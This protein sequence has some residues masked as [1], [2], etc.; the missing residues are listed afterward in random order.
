MNKRNSAKPSGNAPE[1]AAPVRDEAALPLWRQ[2]LREP[3]A[4]CLVVPIALRPWL[5]GITYPTDNFYFLWYLALLFAI[6]SVRLLLRGEA[7]RFGKPIALFAAFFVIA[8]LTGLGTVE[9]Y[10]TYRMLLMWAM[11]FFLFILVTNGI[12]TRLA[13]AILLGAFA[14][15]YLAESLWGLLHLHYVL[16]FVRHLVKAQPGLL[17]QYFGTE[18]LT[19]ELAHRL[20]TNRA[21]GS[22]LFP[23]ALGA[24]LVLGIPYALAG[25][26]RGICE[27][28]T[29]WR[30][31]ASSVAAIPVARRVLHAVLVGATA[32]VVTG[33]AA[34]FLF[35]FFAFFAYEGEPWSEHM[36]AFSL[37]V[38]ALP[39]AL[40]IL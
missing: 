13:A 20:N 36:A 12:R 8:V 9:V 29:A 14:L 11:Y 27:F 21:F 10:T 4:M 26:I 40:S 37:Y 6:W 35:T 19:P 16:P 23:N 17:V 25:S 38:I 39:L 28:L 31:R 32:F 5:D 3:I 7:L 24:F 2:V 1:P 18:E 33:A 22:L 34:F 15:V 30:D